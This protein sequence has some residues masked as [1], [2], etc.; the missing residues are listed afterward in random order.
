MIIT[1]SFIWINYPKTASSFVRDSLRE[2][3]E[4]RPRDFMKAWR[5]R[6][7]SMREVLC[8]ELRPG[9]GDRHGTPTPHGTVTQIPETER[10]LPIASAFRD[11]VERYISLYNYGD[12]KKP[13]QMPENIVEIRKTFPS[14][15][16]LGLADFIR[17]ITFYYGRRKLKVGDMECSIGAHTA[18]F[19]MFFTRKGSIRENVIEYD[20]WDSLQKEINAISFFNSENI[21]HELH[22]WLSILKFHR[23]DIEF[24]MSKPRVN[25]SA[26]SSD[27]KELDAEFIRQVRESEWVL[28]ACMKSNFRNVSAA[29]KAAANASIRCK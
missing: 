13:D 26:R 5:F 28:T 17:Y 12:W 18:D 22:E 15:P 2:L 23:K 10:R 27:G 9:T 6:S 3:Y 11:P 8:P 14:Y 25:V 19:L 1:E 7:R 29:I 20:S 4:I 24:I 16:D 21:S